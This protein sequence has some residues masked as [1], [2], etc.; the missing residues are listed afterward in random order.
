MFIIF[1][2]ILLTSFQI[3]IERG[4]DSGL[5]NRKRRLPRVDIDLLFA[6]GTTVGHKMGLL[7][8]SSNL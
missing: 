5:R 4:A 7:S 2:R 1:I 6:H 8:V 3:N